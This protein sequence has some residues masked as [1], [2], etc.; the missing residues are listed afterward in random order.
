MVTN[1]KLTILALFFFLISQTCTPNYLL[2]PTLEYLFDISNSTYSEL[3]S[4]SF[5]LLCNNISHSQISSSQVMIIPSLKMFV[6][7][8][9]VSLDSSL[10]LHIQPVRKSCLSLQIYPSSE[11]FSHLHCYFSDPSHHCL[12]QT[13]L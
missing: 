13:L 4:S 11:R 10:L 2:T 5:S 3:H 12:I 8:P 6:Q 1:P 9:G 7:K